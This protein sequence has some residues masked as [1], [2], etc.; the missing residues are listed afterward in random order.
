MAAAGMLVA[1]ERLG[2]VRAPGMG[3]SIGAAWRIA[4]HGARCRPSLPRRTMA[5]ASG[6]G[7]APTVEVSA[8]GSAHLEQLYEFARLGLADEA[9]DALYGM[10]DEGLEPTAEHYAA[11]I[12]ACA[13]GSDVER[14]ERWLFRMQALDVQPNL[15]TYNALMWVAAEAGKPEF[16]A[17]WL[18][19]AEAAGFDPDVE[20][21]QALFQ[22]LRKA[23]DKLNVE[24]WAERMMTAGVQPDAACCHSIMGTFADAGMMPKVEEWLAIMEQSFGITPGVE[25]Y[26]VVISGHI[27]A[28][29]IRSAAQLMEEMEDRNLV[30][31]LESY[32]LLIGDEKSFHGYEVVTKWLNKLLK[33]GLEIDAPGYTAIVGALSAAGK[34]SEAEEWFSRMVDEGKANAK[35]LALLVEVLTLRGGAQGPEMAQDWTDQLVETGLALTPA[36][37]AALMANDIFRGDFEQVEARMQRMEGEGLEMNEDSLVALL[38]A[39]ANARPQQ[40]QLAE[41]MFK[42]QMLRGRIEASPTVF[43]ALRSAVG[44]ARCLAL[45]RELQLSK[46]GTDHTEPSAA[47][48]RQKL[49]KRWGAAEKRSQVPVELLSWE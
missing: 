46:E 19:D 12:S 6:A 25:A 24:A 40:S 18:E 2:A 4:E 13:R 43:E 14:A 35:A 45:R 23:G 10:V 5:S 3:F 20:S 39:Y 7:A 1:I 47:K 26:N 48:T 42:Q 16:A 31:N 49:L 33:A 28:G 38:L 37:H 22:A 30:P 8:V 44:G 32:K 36:V 34:A 9:E 29:D 17:R 15:G 11:M 27:A 41:Q 21:Y